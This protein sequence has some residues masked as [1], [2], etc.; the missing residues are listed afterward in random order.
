[1]KKDIILIGGGGH[2]KS[3]IDVIEQEGKFHII[4]IL[5]LPVLV[6]TKILGY[7]IIGTDNDFPKYAKNVNNFLITV[8][9]IKT[10]EKR[11][12]LFNM[13]KSLNVNLPV[14]I[15]PL[16]YVSIT[17]QIAEGSIIMHHALV[18]TNVR[19]G[20]NCIINSKTLIEHDA[21]IGNHCHISTG[22]IING[23]VEVGEETFFGSGAISVH[24][25][26]IPTQAFIKAGSLF[27]SN[28]NMSH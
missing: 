12:S 22:A 1:M 13:V 17:A 28:K 3:C 2:C 23:S 26:K 10:P 4:G 7:R 8:G 11:I 15:S 14:I 9:Q 6:G 16:A 25:A 21:V 27:K 19:I 5:D 20:V 24:G 18:N